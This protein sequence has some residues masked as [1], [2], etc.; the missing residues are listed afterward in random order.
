MFMMARCNE[1]MSHTGS[2]N[3]STSYAS[4]KLC[5]QSLVIIAI[6]SKKIAPN[7]HNVEGLREVAVRATLPLT[8]LVS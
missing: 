4:S 5:Y 2:D 8:L 7:H 1:S 3:L 6:F